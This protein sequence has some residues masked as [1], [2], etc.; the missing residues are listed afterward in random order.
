[1]NG[2]VQKRT[3]RFYRRSRDR[4]ESAPDVGE[5]SA[6]ALRMSRERGEQ[7]VVEN[8]RYAVRQLFRAPTFTIVTILTLALGVGAN[9]AIFSVI[10][11]VLL[12][13]SG[14]QD[15]ERVASFHAKY[16]QLNLPSI[17]VSAPDFAVAQSL[18]GLVDTTAMVQAASFN[19]TFDGRT[20]PLRAGR[21]TVQWFKV[22][23]ARPLHW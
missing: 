23:G 1:M 4:L 13:P 2:Q 19:A 18:P 9:T 16:T 6:L 11:A 8:L 12:H 14:V 5:P 7:P 15:P 22:F 21:V 10:Q 20:Q 3:C 17:G